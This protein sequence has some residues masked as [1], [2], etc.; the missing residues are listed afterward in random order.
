MGGSW[1]NDY[2]QEGLNNKATNLSYNIPLI[3][4]TGGLLY[5]IT[6]TFTEQTYG[7][8]GD[9]G[10]NLT[11]AG[12]GS[13]YTAEGTLIG[14]INSVNCTSAVSDYSTKTNSLNAA[15]DLLGST[16][17]TSSDY[18]TLKID[19]TLDAGPIWLITGGNLSGTV[20]CSQIVAKYKG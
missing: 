7:G 12:T 14:S 18:V 3:S 17:T 13:L 2:K 20:T 11:V 1:V 8:Y 5:S 4:D 6:Y 15:H 10:I 16:F 19:L 9:E